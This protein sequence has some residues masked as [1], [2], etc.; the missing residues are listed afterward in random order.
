M[1]SKKRAIPGLFLFI[2]FLQTIYRIKTLDF[3]RIRTR[4]VGVEDEHADHLTTTTAQEHVF[5]SM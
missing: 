1:C 3:I 4:I 2:F 5:I